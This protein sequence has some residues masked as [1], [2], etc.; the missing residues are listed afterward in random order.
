MSKLNS[1]GKLV[2][3]E[4]LRFT[5]EG[6]TEEGSRSLRE[7]LSKVNLTSK[8]DLA[9]ERDLI[10]QILSATWVLTPGFVAQARSLLKS[11][12]SPSKSSGIHE[13]LFQ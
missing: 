9:L 10:F 11:Y 12:L 1:K 7:N 2:R 5:S 4:S 8:K 3:L 6:E 13:K